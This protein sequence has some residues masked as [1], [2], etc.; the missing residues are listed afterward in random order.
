[1][2]G[3]SDLLADLGSVYGAEQI[4]ADLR[5][6]HRPSLSGERRPLVALNTVDEIARRTG[7][8]DRPLEGVLD[9]RGAAELLVGVA[10]DRIQR[11]AR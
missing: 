5:A 4:L 11:G 3:V 1:M 2:A 6:G 7:A 8:G 10:R 9:G